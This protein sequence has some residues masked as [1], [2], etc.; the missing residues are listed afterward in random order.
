MSMLPENSSP[1]SQMPTTQSA[2]MAAL[3][4][5]LGAPGWVRGRL[6][7]RVGVGVGVGVRV[8]VRVRVVHV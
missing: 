2:M 3:R 4:H 6:R 1:S 5:V 8:R 7:V